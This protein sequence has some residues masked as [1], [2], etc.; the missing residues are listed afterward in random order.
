MQ[1][2]FNMFTHIYI[3]NF[4]MSYLS[5]AAIIFILEIHICMAIS[6][7]SI[8]HKHYI[9]MYVFNDCIMF[10]LM[11]FEQQLAF[12]LD[13]G[14]LS[15]LLSGLNNSIHSK[16]QLCRLIIIS[17]HGR[18]LFTRIFFFTIYD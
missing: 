13:V 5:N 8:G 10:S 14:F 6:E 7:Y 15:S 4:L 3:N 1:Q 18:V 12:K 11:Q 2:L 17:L 16:F 9:H